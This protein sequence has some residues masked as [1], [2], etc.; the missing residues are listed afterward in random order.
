MMR[1]GQIIQQLREEAKMLQSELAQKLGLGRTTI[2]NYEN[3]YSYPDLDTLIAIAQ[4]FG[5]STDY[6]L[7][8]SDLRNPLDNMTEQ[9][10]KVTN[11]YNRLNTEN[12]DYIIGEMIKLYREQDNPETP[13]KN[14]G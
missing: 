2:S 6:L 14:I 11:Y 1:I 12:Q 3:N 10:T 4:L 13:Q 7:G 8:I 5:V 9:E